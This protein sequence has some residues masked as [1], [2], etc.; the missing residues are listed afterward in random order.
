MKL[1]VLV[2]VLA[3]LLAVQGVIAQDQIIINSQDWRD[4]YTGMQYGHLTGVPSN[5]LVSTRHSTILLYSISTDKD[6]ILVLSSRN[7]PFITGYESILRSRG[8]DAPEEIAASNLNLELLERLEGIDKFIVLDDAYGYNAIS[9]APYAVVDGW[10]VVFADED[11]ID[12]VV[13]ALEE[14]SPREVLIYGQVDR[15]V[16]DALQQFDPEILNNGNRFDN[17]IEIVKRYIEVKPTR[18]VILT[19]GEFIESGLMSG[20]DPV[21]FLGQENV[22]ESVRDFIEDSG[23]EVG[24]LIGN[25]LVN[26]ATFIRRA[27]GISVF[28]KFAQGARQPTGAISTVEDLDRFPMPRYEINLDVSSIVYNRATGALEVTYHNTENLATYFKS[29]IT[30]R[31]GTDVVVLGDARPVFLDKNE[32][33]T[34]VY[35]ADTEGDPL[36]FQSNDLSGDVFVIYGEGPE[37]L[38]KTYQATFDIDVI[39]VLDDAEIEIR[40]A[41]YDTTARE[42]VVVVGSTG[43]APA[44]VSAEVVDLL[45]NGEE[46]TVGGDGVVLIEPGDEEKIGV[47]VAMADEDFADNP[48]VLVR[49]FYG[50]RELS[51]IKSKEARFPLVTRTGYLAY[52]P[53]AVVIVLVLLLLIWLGTKK[54]C[55]SCGRKNPRGRKTCVGCKKRF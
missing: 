20:T 27:L 25:E 4:V 34:V 7:R 53:Y 2:L 9:V 11:N 3:A 47:V 46:L 1:V 31:D 17:N 13:S 15:D 41:Y 19:N 43:E 52:A 48:T 33:K 12:D 42:F 14:K 24:I 21:L 44:Y 18:Q 39:E 55:K 28:V 49:A 22:P 8:Y 10:F 26:T 54:T 29:T 38:E 36:S 32:Y 16:K 23:I 50:E 40:D 6:E 37:S 45:V 5:F 35:S 51:R 30:V